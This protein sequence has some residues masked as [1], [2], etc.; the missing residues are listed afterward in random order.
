[1]PTSEYSKYSSNNSWEWLCSRMGC[2]SLDRHSSSDVWKK[3]KTIIEQKDVLDNKVKSLLDI[4][5]EI[6]DIGSKIDCVKV[7]LDGLEARIGNNKSC[8]GTL[9]KKADALKITTTSACTED[10]ISEISGHTKR[11]I[12]IM[13]YNLPESSGSSVEYRK[14]HYTEYIRKLLDMFQ[15]DSLLI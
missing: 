6:D 10:L 1:M 9:V 13:V 2:S 15:V 14:Q 4:S 11:A 7:K 12:K 5:V 8:F 3:L